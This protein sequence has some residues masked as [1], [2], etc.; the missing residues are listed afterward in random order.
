MEFS[1]LPPQITFPEAR[2]PFG[3]WKEGE[4][5]AGGEAVNQSYGMSTREN[6]VLFIGSL[7]KVQG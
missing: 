3:M 4:E 7:F 5:T 2:I 1:F 6:R